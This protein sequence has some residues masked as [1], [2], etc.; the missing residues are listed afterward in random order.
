MAAGVDVPEDAIGFD[1]SIGVDA[2]PAR[3]AVLNPQIRSDLIADE[4]MVFSL[5]RG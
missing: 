5:L 1:D 4:Y 3:K 2:Q